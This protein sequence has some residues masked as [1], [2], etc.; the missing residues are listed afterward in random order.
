MFPKFRKSSS[1]FQNRGYHLWH[2]H[3]LLTA[4]ACARGLTGETVVSVLSTLAR[5]IA[6]RA[7]LDGHSWCSKDLLGVLVTPKDFAPRHP[8]LTPLASAH[9][10]HSFPGARSSSSSAGGF[11]QPALQP[12]SLGRLSV[13]RKDVSPRP[14][15]DKRP[16]DE[17]LHHSWCHLGTVHEF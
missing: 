13:A 10:V 9:P 11:G 16:H 15:L 14:F 6:S 7:N 3:V 1:V 17:R 8:W 5:L 12:C 4:I 2:P